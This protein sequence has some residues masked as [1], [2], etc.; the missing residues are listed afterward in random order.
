MYDNIAISKVLQHFHTGLR[1]NNEQA[2]IPTVTPTSQLTPVATPTTVT[3]QHVL[4]DHRRIG[5]IH[6]NQPM[7]RDYPLPT[8]V[9]Y[10]VTVSTSPHVGPE[11][12]KR[13]RHAPITKPAAKPA[14]TVVRRCTTSNLSAY[15]NPW[16]ARSQNRRRH[17][18]GPQTDYA[19]LNRGTPNFIPT[20]S[21]A[22][23]HPLDG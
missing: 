17:G 12:L 20:L 13:D 1:V 9:V 21:S 5:H 11:S 3:Y 14:D 10:E 7:C 4:R 2:T 22:N 18:H 6:N 19:A 8:A 23:F 15:R 16:F